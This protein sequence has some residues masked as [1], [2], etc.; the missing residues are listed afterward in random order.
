MRA[1]WRG[2][3]TFGLVSIPIS[4]YPATEAKDVRFHLFDRE[5]RRVRYRRVVEE[6]RP[7]ARSGGDRETADQEV[8]DVATD[9]GAAAAGEGR[10]TTDAAAG[11]ATASAEREVAYEDLMR[12]YEVEPDR[13]VLLTPD[14]IARAR[15][16]PSRAIE[17]EDFV[18][19]EDIDPVYFEKAYHVAPTTGAEKP[20]ALLAGALGE[21]GRVGIGRFVLR[22]KPH[23]VAIRPAGEALMLQTLYFGDEVRGVAPLTGTLGG[24]EVR[25]RELDVARSLVET[26]A[27]DWDPARYDDEYRQELLRM[28]AERA[29]EPVERAGPVTATERRSGRVDELMETLRR[30]V[31]EAKAARGGKGGQRAG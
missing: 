15:P 4:L 22:T 1:V 26:L 25:R 7:D 20:Y 28:I 17:L 11:P 6:A 12:G 18:R 23:L 13:Y 3:L 16:S 10:E 21:A 8:A 5:G 19:L 9:A 27:T 2:S 24:V 31:E 29:P 30:S 14:E